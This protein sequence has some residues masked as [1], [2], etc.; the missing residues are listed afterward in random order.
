MAGWPPALQPSLILHTCTSLG[1]PPWPTASQK[2]LAPHLPPHFPILSPVSFLS[3]AQLSYISMLFA[4]LF[5]T[6]SSLLS[7]FTPLLPFRLSCPHL[8]A[9]R[10]SP[11]LSLRCLMQSD[12]REPLTHFVPTTG[13]PPT[14]RHALDTHARTDTDTQARAGTHMQ[15]HTPAT[16][17]TEN[18]AHSTSHTF[19]HTSARDMH[20]Q[21]QR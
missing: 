18:S 8:G 21:G 6:F 7:L 12:Y 5:L 17:D 10:G 19:L 13:T 14:S 1:S 2:D 16:R 11:C 4:L 15:R 9:G 20:A 3:P